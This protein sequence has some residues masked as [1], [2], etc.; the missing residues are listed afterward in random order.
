M[1]NQF[2]EGK[3]GLGAHLENLPCVY[4]W[5]KD[6]SAVL[7]WLPPHLTFLLPDQDTLPTQV[8]I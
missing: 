6:Q 2:S 8:V 5:P 7:S 3:T 1:S 4:I